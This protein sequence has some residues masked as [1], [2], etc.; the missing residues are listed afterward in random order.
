MVL[1]GKTSSL[2]EDISKI[3]QDHDASAVRAHLLGLRE[4]FRIHGGL[5][6]LPSTFVKYIYM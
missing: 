3:G 4:L 6:G 2:T 1:K 5:K